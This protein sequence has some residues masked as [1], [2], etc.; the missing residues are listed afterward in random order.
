MET[1]KLEKIQVSKTNPRKHFDEKALAELTDSVKR[2]GVLQPVLV[3]S[4]N[5]NGTFE[6]VAGERRYRAV[7]AAKAL[8]VKLQRDTQSSYDHQRKSEAAK[9]RAEQFVVTRIFATIG[10]KSKG[11]KPD[12]AF[13][14]TVATTLAGSI[15]FVGEKHLWA[16]RGETKEIH[17]YAEKLVKKTPDAA[18]PGVIVELIAAAGISPY[19]SLYGENLKAACD[20]AG[21]SIKNVEAQVK[22]E[23]KPAKSNG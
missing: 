14:R 19:G 15:A 5:G 3:R 10:E 9:R 4:M 13:L 16:A 23:K 18:L 11:I 2:H 21:I 22:A 1:L 7:K 20:L 12:A 6:L 8:G 17:C